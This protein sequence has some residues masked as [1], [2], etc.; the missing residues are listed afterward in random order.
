[1]NIKNCKKIVLPK[2]GNISLGSLSVIEANNQVPFDIKRVY[3]IYDLKECNALRGK[4]AHRETE[5]A[6]FCL[7]GS[8]SL[9]LDDGE[10]QERILIDKANEGVYLGIELWHDMSDFS[11]D[12]VMLVLASDYYREE[13]YLRDYSEFLQYINR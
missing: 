12:C 6:I 3:Y 11:E 5:Q 1:M 10:N 2:I 9:G 7:K 13:D 4:H 8:F